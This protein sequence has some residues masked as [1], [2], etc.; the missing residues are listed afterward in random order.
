MKHISSISGN[1]LRLTAVGLVCAVLCPPAQAGDTKPFKAT[2][3]ANPAMY[4]VVAAGGFQDDFFVDAREQYGLEFIGLVSL[5]SIR[6]NVGGD[7][8]ALAQETIYFDWQGSGMT[9]GLICFKLVTANGDI[10]TIT[11]EGLE[12]PVT[13]S[14]GGPWQIV[15]EKCTGRFAGATGHGT[16]AG[17][18]VSFTYTLTGEITTPGSTRKGN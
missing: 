12:D 1:I 17:D 16:M 9:M 2:G 7:G 6:S 11:A 15:P 10:L 8:N 14:F 4:S 3:V 18:A 13:L 5:Q